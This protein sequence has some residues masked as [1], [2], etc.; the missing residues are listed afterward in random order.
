VYVDAVK[1]GSWR[2]TR[3]DLVVEGGGRRIDL[4]G[5]AAPNRQPPRPKT[6]SPITE[7]AGK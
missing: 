2:L 7:P 1:N 5:G 4:R 3:L 6:S